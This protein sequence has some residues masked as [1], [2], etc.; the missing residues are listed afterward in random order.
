[1]PM[2]GQE[3]RELRKTTGLTQEQFADEIGLSRKSV[4]EAEAL[5]D[6]HVGRRTESAVRAI[7]RVTKA[8]SRLME[9]AGQHQATGDDTEAQLYMCAANFLR[10]SFATDEDTIFNLAISA[11]HLRQ[12]LD[13]CLTAAS[14]H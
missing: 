6:Q 5:G 12:E 10:G 7:T 1:M 11:A 13:R 2:T 8:R 9:M 14:S 4:N 3:M